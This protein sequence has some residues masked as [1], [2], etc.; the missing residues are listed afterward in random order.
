M[1][2]QSAQFP[3]VRG[4]SVWNILKAYQGSIYKG[5]VKKNFLP[6]DAHAL[7]ILL[8]I[9]LKIT[10]YV[11]ECG[12]FMLATEVFVYLVKRETATLCK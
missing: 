8:E 9:K 6:F 5:E 7:R 2:C 3:V 12:N 10:C 1:Y 11:Q 4:I